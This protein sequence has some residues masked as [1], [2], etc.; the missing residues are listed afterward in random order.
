MSFNF[1]AAVTHHSDFGALENKICHCFP[2]FPIFHI[3]MGPDAMILV[4]RQLFHSPLL[5]SSRG[6]LVTLCILPL[7]GVI[8]ISEVIDV[9]PSNV[10]SRV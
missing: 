10:D 7:G 2:Y 1:M 3:V 5:L 9:S 6:S 4:L 8:C